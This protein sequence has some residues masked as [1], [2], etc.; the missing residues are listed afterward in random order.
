MKK[1]LFSIDKIL[2]VPLNFDEPKYIN[3]PEKKINNESKIVFNNINS[4]F[5]KKFNDNKI[6]DNLNQQAINIFLII[7][8]MKIVLI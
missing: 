1:T 2:P 4:Y 7:I 5:S 6:S 3:S 8:L